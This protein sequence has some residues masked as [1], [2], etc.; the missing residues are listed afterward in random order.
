MDGGER[1]RDGDGHD[2]NLPGRLATSPFGPLLR[3]TMLAA[4][5]LLVMALILV[6]IADRGSD[7]QLA[8]GTPDL[9]MMAVG[10]IDA[11]TREYTVRRSV[12]QTPGSAPCI[13]LSNGT[14]R[15]GC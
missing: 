10:S 4:G 6:P 15:G 9:D 13:V 5:A 12:L 11:P 14:T 2:G 1:L 8:A 7:T 3:S